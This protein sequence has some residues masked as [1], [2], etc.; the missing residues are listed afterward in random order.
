V[1]DARQMRIRGKVQNEVFENYAS[2]F[3]YGYTLCTS[4]EAQSAIAELRVYTQHK[5]A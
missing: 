1:L 5:Q 4:N 3:Y 2:S